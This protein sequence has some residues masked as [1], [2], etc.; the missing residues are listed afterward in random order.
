MDW[1]EGRTT[2]TTS[3]FDGNDEEDLG[4][5][6]PLPLG[7]ATRQMREFIRT[8]RGVAG[9]TQGFILPGGGVNAS[10]MGDGLSVIPP[11]A[12]FPYRD[13][14]ISRWRKKEPWLE[15]CLTHK[16]IT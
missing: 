6:G 12:N 15:V 3:N 4:S 10:M 14:L 9:R 5:S 11:S 8:Y 16:R 13:Q 1:D 7:E 2:Y